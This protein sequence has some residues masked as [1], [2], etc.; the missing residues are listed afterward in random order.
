LDEQVNRLG[1]FSETDR[2]QHVDEVEWPPAANP[3]R[4]EANPPTLR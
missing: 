3:R 2:P 4:S 1:Q